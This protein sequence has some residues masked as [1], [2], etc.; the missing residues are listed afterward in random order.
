MECDETCY[1]TPIADCTE[2][3]DSARN[4]GQH[5]TLLTIHDCTEKAAKY[6]HAFG[7]GLTMHRVAVSQGDFKTS[8]KERKNSVCTPL[9]HKLLV[10]M[11]IVP[12]LNCMR[13]SSDP[14]RDG[15]KSALEQCR[16]AKQWNSQSTS[17]ISW[18]RAHFYT[19]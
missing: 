2:V 8:Q 14:G 16:N 7:F 18:C 6:W 11:T 1:F 9:S 12:V 3:N 5:C 10:K 19:L 17:E 4:T 13:M 15:F